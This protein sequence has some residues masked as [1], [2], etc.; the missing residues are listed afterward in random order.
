MP[1]PY[2]VGEEGRARGRPARPRLHRPEPGMRLV[3]DITFIA[4]GEGWLYLAT[5]LDLATREIV[6]YSMADHHRASLVVDAL[7][8]APPRP[9]LRR[10]RLTSIS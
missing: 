3:G 2:P 1:G 5:W 4:I 9:G 7:S 6:G 8:M 10:S